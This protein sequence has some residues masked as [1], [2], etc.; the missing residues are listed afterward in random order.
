MRMRG[1]W[2]GERDLPG[3]EF[4]L[5][6]WREIGSQRRGSKSGRREVT[7]STC[8]SADLRAAPG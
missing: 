3:L 1:N 8:S 2:I 7:Y 5:L 6:D 4:L